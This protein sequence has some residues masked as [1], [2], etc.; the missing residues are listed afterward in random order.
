[1]EQAR[2]L[3]AIVLSALI[4]L[5]SGTSAFAIDT[6]DDGLIAGRNCQA[7]IHNT[8]SYLTGYSAGFGEW[9]NAVMA[10]KR[11]PKKKIDTKKGFDLN[12]LEDYAQYAR[13]VSQGIGADECFDNPC[14][15]AICKELGAIVEKLG[16]EVLVGSG[17][18]SPRKM[19]LPITNPA[20][21]ITRTIGIMMEIN[22]RLFS[23]AT[24]TGFS[25]S[26]FT[27]SASIKFLGSIT[28]VLDLLIASLKA[29][30]ISP[31]DRNL[32]SGSF[33]KAFSMRL[34]LV[35]YREDVNTTLAP[36]R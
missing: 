7:S 17:T 24:D 8:D 1:M 30:A 13:D 26:T 12:K 33:D 36:P 9:L 11:N 6:Y 19:L 28:V 22:F 29:F 35:Q 4:F 25:P 20:V 27:V 18:A 15:Q 10:K 34:S 21:P 23:G 32:S 14:Q 2:L 5:L 31:A 3:I 16:S